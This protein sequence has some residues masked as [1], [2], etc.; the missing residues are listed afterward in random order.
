MARLKDNIFGHETFFQL[1]ETSLSRQKWPH[2]VLLTGPS[3]IGKTSVALAIAQALV[4][5]NLIDSKPC[6]HCGSCLRV[7]KKQSEKMIIIE[8]DGLFIKVAQIRDVQDFLS[9][10]HEGEA[11]IIILQQANLLN[12]Q[13]ANALLKSLEEPTEGVYFILIGLDS[14][15]LMPTIKSRCQNMRLMPLTNQH[16]KKIKP[17]LED[18]MYI[19][20][21]GSLEKLNDLSAQKDT[22]IRSL[23]AH[24]LDQFFTDPQFLLNDQWRKTL[25]DRELTSGICQQ[26]T[27][28]LRDILLL[29][30]S[31]QAPIIHTDLLPLFTQLKTLIKTN[32]SDFAQDLYQVE[33]DIRGNCDSVLVFESLWVKNVR[34]YGS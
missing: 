22:N 15:L 26:W 21:R 25:K 23:G 6:G 11:R 7:E 20:A 34:A 4:C 8:P 1:F 29:E 12:P 18:W 24:L 13:A 17:G 31:S 28:F 33:K 16:L 9:L 30:T 5:E 14:E 10:R 32:W 27:Q 3:G 19:S 2:A